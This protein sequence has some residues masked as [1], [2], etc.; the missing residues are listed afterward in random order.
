MLDSE[1]IR[2]IDSIPLVSSDEKGEFRLPFSQIPFGKT[3][4]I[5][6]ETGPDLLGQFTI[7]DASIILLKKGYRSLVK[8]LD[9]DTTKTVIL[10][11]TLIAE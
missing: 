1:H 5:T 10:D 8:S 2:Q 4:N 11:F 6:D 7:S 9:S 3:I